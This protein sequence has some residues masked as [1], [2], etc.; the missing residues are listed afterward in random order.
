MLNIKYSLHSLN[1]LLL[2]PADFHILCVGCEAL[3][4]KTERAYVVVGISNTGVSWAGTHRRYSNNDVP[5]SSENLESLRIALVPCHYSRPFDYTTYL[6]Y[7]ARNQVLQGLGT[8]KMTTKE[9]S[10][11]AII[12]R[13]AESEVAISAGNRSIAAQSINETNLT[14]NIL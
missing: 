8:I 11:Y 4:N 7:D 10:A 5:A 13:T 2:V 12:N 14:R 6:D 1:S 3:L 9:Y